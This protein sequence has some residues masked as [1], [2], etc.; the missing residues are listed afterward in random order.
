[1]KIFM[2]AFGKVMVTVILAGLL[3]PCRIRAEEVQGRPFR[4]SEARQAAAGRMAEILPPVVTRTASPQTDVRAEVQGG[5]RNGRAGGH[6]SAPRAVPVKKAGSAYG[7]PSKQRSGP[8]AEPAEAVQPAAATDVPAAA[9]SGAGN[10]AVTAVPPPG[11]DS[12]ADTGGDSPGGRDGSGTIDLAALEEELGRI[13]DEGIEEA[14][15]EQRQAFEKE[16]ARLW[17]SRSFWRR[18]AI[19]EGGAIVACLLGGFLVWNWSGR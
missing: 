15:A 6:P 5:L 2:T 14:L 17:D 19:G 11:D 9:A 18:A 13:L 3:L 7:K 12:G 8:A 16:Y 1:M 10:R 4:R